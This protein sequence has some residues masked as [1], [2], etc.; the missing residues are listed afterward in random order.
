[1]KSYALLCP[2]RGRVQ[3][4]LRFAKSVLATADYLER[5]S[6][7][8]YLDDDDSEL[9]RYRSTLN[10]LQENINSEV[11][12][13]IIQGPRIGVPRAVN[14]L[15]EKCQAEILL[16]ASDDQVYIDRGWD[17]KLEE[18]IAKIPDKIFCFWYNDGRESKNFCTFPIVSRQWVDTLGYFFFPFFEHYFTDTWVWMLAKSIKRDVYLPGIMAEHLHWKIGK[19]ELDMTYKENV[20]LLGNSR[21]TR[22]RK[23][24]DRFERYFL[25]D[26]ELLRN[27]ITANGSTNTP[28]K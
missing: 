10:S 1:M 23:V 27:K 17:V 21:H 13:N 12:I 15:A 26:V 3:G 4:A 8:F 20:S 11:S 9:E 2:T 7:L 24:I 18:E 28:D 22:D 16:Y 19:S 25:A 6:L 14:L 5:L